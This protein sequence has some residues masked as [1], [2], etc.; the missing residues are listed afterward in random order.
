[1]GLAACKFIESKANVCALGPSGTGKTH[2][3]AA[4][5]AEAIERGHSV[6]FYRVNDLLVR[7]NEAKGEKRLDALNA[8]LKK[9]S[10]LCLD[11]LGYASVN[12]KNAELLFNVAASRHEVGGTYITSN[13]PFSKW[14]GFLGNAAMTAALIEKLTQNAVALNMNGEPYR[15]DAP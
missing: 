13:Y 1:M 8:A 14:A 12:T 3:M 6:R 15:P 7:L 5:A 2:L 9:C 11:E 10:L 4:I